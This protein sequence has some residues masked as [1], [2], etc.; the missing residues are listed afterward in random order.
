MIA[1]IY[2]N[3]Q[4]D[5][6]GKIIAVGNQDYALVSDL[7]ALSQTTEDEIIAYSSGGQENA[8]ELVSNYNIVETVNASGDSCKL[9][10]AVINN[11][12]EV[13]NATL[14][15]MSLYPADEETFVNAS[16]SLGANIPITLAGGNGIRFVCYQTGIYRF[17]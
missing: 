13:F 10:A 14:T 12:R 3:V 4:I 7:T 17:Y 9:D 2:N 1:G 15:D 16:T 11:V 6:T 5:V 8:T